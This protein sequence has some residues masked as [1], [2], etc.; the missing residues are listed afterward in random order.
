MALFPTILIIT[1]ADIFKENISSTNTVRSFIGAW[2]KEKLYQIVC[3]DTGFG[4][5]GVQDNNV[6]YL[7]HQDIILGRYHL[8]KRNKTQPL[9]EGYVRK[10]KTFVT[11]IKELGRYIYLS[12]PYNISSSLKKFIDKSHADIIYVPNTSPQSFNL[13]ERISKRYNLPILPHFFDDWPNAI[14]KDAEWA[15]ILRL[16]FERWFKRFMRRCSSIICI[17][18]AM[19][20]EY[21]KRYGEKTYT[22]LMR[23]VEPWPLKGKQQDGIIDFFYAGSLYLGRNETIAI[24]AKSVE[25]LGL[26]DKVRINIYTSERDWKLSSK[27]F[28]NHR[29]LKYGGHINQQQLRNIIDTKTDVV[30]MIE[31][32]SE[33]YLDFTR[34]S[35][36]T[37]IVED[38]ASGHPIFAIGN[39]EQGSIL[40]L[41]ENGAAITATNEAGIKKGLQR[42]MNGD[43]LEGI[44]KAAKSLFYSNHTT[45]AQEEKFYNAVITAINDKGHGEI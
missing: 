36:S 31:S 17:G 25:K 7:E 27:L 24:L 41:E 30:L 8:K 38:L 15:W 18:D 14:Y 11:K 3:K 22:P 21:R 45:K 13:A 10:E 19:C 42:I 28:S 44:T 34:L 6:F 43:D 9:L 35:M 40:Y 16:I 2:P 32:F 12:L 4:L 23:S 26:S 29:S 33:Q 5:R 39:K 1:G 20:K 37:K